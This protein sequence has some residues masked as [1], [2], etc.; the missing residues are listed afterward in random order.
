MSA[1]GQSAP[2]SRAP[3]RT[4]SIVRLTPQFVSGVWTQQQ[5][6][7]YSRTRMN[8]RSM[9]F[10]FGIVTEHLVSVQAL[11]PLTEDEYDRLFSSEHE[12]GRNSFE[13]VVTAS[14]ADAELSSLNLIGWFSTR[15]RTG[16][17]GNDI[18]FHNR[19]FRRASDVAL[20]LKPEQSSDLV[21]E[22]YARSSLARFSTGNYRWA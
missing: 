21:A 6:L 15:S 8:S 20:V 1:A 11:K 19:Y 10:L 12:L 7:A 9:G 16:L 14:K 2:V 3:R 18:E 4:P 5:R 17:F 22:L 13:E